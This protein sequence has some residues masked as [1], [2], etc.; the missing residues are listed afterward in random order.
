MRYALSLRP[1]KEEDGGG[2]VKQR[3]RDVTSGNDAIG[4]VLGP[5][6]NE[7]SDPPSHDIAY[8]FDTTTLVVVSCQIRSQTRALLVSKT[9]NTR[10]GC[11]GHFSL[12]PD[13]YS[14]QYVLSPRR[15]PRNTPTTPSTS[16]ETVGRAHTTRA[17]K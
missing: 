15:G 2:G 11:D 1:E 8:P 7:T 10:D 5:N 4:R 17:T 6:T 14:R 9:N 16:E 12:S 3:K 13:P